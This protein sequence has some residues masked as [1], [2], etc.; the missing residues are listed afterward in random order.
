MK[1]LRLLTFIILFVV[2]IASF[3]QAVGNN[4]IEYAKN[5][6]IIL[7]HGIGDDHTCLADEKWNEKG[8]MTTAKKYLEDMGLTGYVYAY[9]FSDK[10]LNIEKEGWEFGDRNYIIPKQLVNVAT[11]LIKQ[12]GILVRGH[13]GK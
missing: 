1:I 6:L 8:L 7:V 2:G 4:D 11:K 13:I 9:E 5:Y 12:G 10:F 3:A